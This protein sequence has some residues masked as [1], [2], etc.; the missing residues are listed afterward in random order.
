MA[1]LLDPAWGLRKN[2]GIPRPRMGTSEKGGI[3]RPRM[4][5]SEKWRYCRTPH[6]DF[7]KM[8]LPDSVIMK[9]LEN[10]GIARPCLGTSDIFLDLA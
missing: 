2:G 8:V 7:G 5:T 4:G 10:G 9:T 6:G 1:V 3:P